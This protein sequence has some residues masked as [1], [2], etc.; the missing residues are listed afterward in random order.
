ME[1]L[2]NGHMFAGFRLGGDGGDDVNVQVHFDVADVDVPRADAAVVAFHLGPA[3]DFD[4]DCATGVNA[5]VDV[6][7]DV[8]AAP[9]V[10]DDAV[11]D[12]VAENAHSFGRPEQIIP[13]PKRPET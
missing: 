2:I 12:D 13:R 1:K 4:V 6:S 8:D 11:N 10:D 5:G 9:H 3:A 7:V